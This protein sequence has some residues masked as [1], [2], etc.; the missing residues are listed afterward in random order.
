M[1]KNTWYYLAAGLILSV[2]FVHCQ[3]DQSEG[4]KAAVRPAFVLVAPAQTSRMISYID[5]TGTI[6]AD[7]SSEVLSPV[8]GVIEAL[9]VREN[10]RATRDQLIAVINPTERLSLIGNTQW[11]LKQLQ[12]AYQASAADSTNR[13]RISGQ[14][15][16]LKKSLAFARTVYQ[17]VPVISPLNGVVTQRWLDMGSQVKSRDKIV[18]ISD[19]N[20]LLIRAEINEKYYTALQSARALPVLLAAYPEETFNGRIFTIYPQV[21]AGSRNIKFDVKIENR[22][23]WKLLPGMMAQIRIPTRV[24]EKAVSV[25]EEALLTTIDGQQF[26]FI[27]DSDSMAHR[28]GVSTGI[29]MDNRVEILAGIEAAEKVVV[30]GQQMVRDNAKVKLVAPGKEKQK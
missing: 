19:L 3:K 11:A 5:I 1:R 13:V 6:Q 30:M 4:K 9:Y 16:S 25:P 28:R 18:T 7:I 21:D 14:I 12:Q 20:S 29:R 15:D 26:L 10:A 24:S 17:T 27:V 8:D 2:S 22:G 23:V